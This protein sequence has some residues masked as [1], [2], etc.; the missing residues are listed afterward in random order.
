VKGKLGVILQREFNDTVIVFVSDFIKVVDRV[1]SE[2]EAL[3]WVTDI[4]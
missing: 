4:V 2:A 1:L 3:G